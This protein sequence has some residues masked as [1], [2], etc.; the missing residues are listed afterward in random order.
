MRKA[1]RY[2]AAATHTAA[3]RRHRAAANHAAPAVNGLPDTRAVVQC[4]ALLLQ[5][6]ADLR[7][8]GK[9]FRQG[10]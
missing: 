1:G 10:R 6:V 4:D 8:R 2:H 3:A 5:L 9:S 7:T